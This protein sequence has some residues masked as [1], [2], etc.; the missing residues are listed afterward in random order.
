MNKAE[1]LARANCDQGSVTSAGY[2][3][4]W[5][6]GVQAQIDQD[7]EANRKGDA[8]V[9]IENASQ[10]TEV[11]V[12]QTSHQFIFGSHLFNF[13]QLGTDERNAAHKNLFGTVFNSATIPFYWKQFELEEGKPRFTQEERDTAEFWNSVEEPEKQP[14]WRRPASDPLVKFCED[15]GIRSHGHTM[16]WGSRRWQI[17]DWVYDK[18]PARYRMSPEQRAG[19]AMN[20]TVEE[21]EP[22]SASEI[23]A[24]IP[25][26]TTAMHSLA[27]KRIFEIALRYKDRI[28]S[29]DVINESAID[30]SKGL[31]VP[32]AGVC[33]STYGPM[34]GD[35]T[36]RFLKIAETVLPRSVII[37]INDYLLTE[38]YASQVQD[39]RNRGC[40]IDV[41]GAQMH[42]FDP[43]TC[44]AMADGKSDE[45][46]P[47]KVRAA[48]Q[49]LAKAGVPLHLSEV[50]IPAP[51]SAGERDG[52]IQAVIAR[53]LYRLWF[54]LK[55]MMGITWWNLVDGCGA[56]KE[57]L[58]SGLFTREMQP[59]PVFHVLE[60][61][62]NN[63]WKT[64]TMARVDSSG[65]IRFRGFAGKY[66]LSWV[67]SS[68]KE[69]IKEYTLVG[70]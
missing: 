2:L 52:M 30:Y 22:L 45:Q 26:Y 34:P 59:K 25:E 57:P 14:H 48:M 61:L 70:Q 9:S 66:N 12:E 19:R 24:L 18:L 62:I 65:Q 31:M 40:K 17:P 41:M 47:T 28:H 58:V 7:I 29:W 51:P 27:A 38:D 68:G 64:R 13:D 50:T 33:K 55:P 36:Y 6:Q 32:E 10:G 21:F 44:H 60:D 43:Q 53:N 23:E 67:D 56:F 5:N 42:I 3:S 37:N 20:F 35:Y 39:L 49:A 69:S 46:S 4:L 1:I 16:V 63:Q 54:S 15:K 8:C 11:R